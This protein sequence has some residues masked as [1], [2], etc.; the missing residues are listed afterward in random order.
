[1]RMN[2]WKQENPSSGPDALNEGAYS[3]PPGEAIRTGEPGL[4]LVFVMND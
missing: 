2:G 1:M 4:C 3:L